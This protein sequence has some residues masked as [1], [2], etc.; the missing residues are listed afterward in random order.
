MDTA[1]QAT[2]TRISN[3]TAE[4][5]CGLETI[6]AGQ[7]ACES[8]EYSGLIREAIIWLDLRPTRGCGQLGSLRIVD[9]ERGRFTNLGDTIVRVARHPPESAFEE[10]GDYTKSLGTGRFAA[11]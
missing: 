4:R 5:S 2:K 1:T 9:S 8:K 3:R 11:H 6:L 7:R 10:V